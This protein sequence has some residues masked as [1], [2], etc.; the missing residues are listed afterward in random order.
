[1]AETLDERILRA[2]HEDVANVPYDPEWPRPFLKEKEY[3]LACLPRE[4]IGRV[5]HFGSTA[6]PGLAA[7]PIVDTLVEVTSLDEQEAG[8]SL[9][10]NHKGTTTSGGRRGAMT[11]RHSMPGLSSEIPA[12]NELIT[13]T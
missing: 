8:S 1:M 6:V 11:R 3:L 13:S 4:L 9:F 5:E 7:K 12:A 2:V 10:W